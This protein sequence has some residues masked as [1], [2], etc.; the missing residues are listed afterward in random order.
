[1]TKSFD[2]IAAQ[3]GHDV[4]VSRFGYL[5]PFDPL[6]AADRI[7]AACATALAGTALSIS[8]TDRDAASLS[9]AGLAGSATDLTAVHDHALD[10]LIRWIDLRLP[11]DITW[12]PAAVTCPG[13]PA[14]G[15]YPAQVRTDILG[16]IL[17]AR[18]T[19]T[20]ASDIGEDL[21]TTDGHDP[22]G[23]QRDCDGMVHAAVGVRWRRYAGGLRRRIRTAQPADPELCRIDD[24]IVSRQLAKL[25]SAAI[26][27]AA[28][29]LRIWLLAYDRA[30]GHGLHG[31]GLLDAG[32]PAALDVM[33]PLSTDHDP[34]R[35]VAQRWNADAGR[36]GLRF[37]DLDPVQAEDAVHLYVSTYTDVLLRLGAM[38]VRGQVPDTTR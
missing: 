8:A 26:D 32:D 30:S 13:S 14:S 38:Q 21:R 1:M 16:R 22:V 24:E 25:E 10:L 36:Q 18:F 12:R 27:D 23:W 7:A 17:D 5:L 6:I 28:E 34:A 33:S 3:I 4:V 31:R 15:A 29:A 20:V 9:G 11:P 2:V 35:H 19:C 37:C